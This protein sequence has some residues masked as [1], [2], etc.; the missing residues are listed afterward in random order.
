MANGDTTSTAQNRQPVCSAAYPNSS[1]LKNKAAE[2]SFT[3]HYQPITTNSLAFHQSPLTN[4]QLQALPP[5]VT[6]LHPRANRHSTQ[7]TTDSPAKINRKPCRL[8]I[9]ISPTKQ[10][11]ATQINRKLLSTLRI[12]LSQVTNHYSLITNHLQHSHESSIKFRPRRT[13]FRPHPPH[14]NIRLCVILPA[15]RRPSQ[16]TQYC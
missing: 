10:T 5:H 13:L 12:T 11:P 9:A 15:H 2:P 14:H 3:D 4:H 16:P 6:L 7:V 8:E 1:N